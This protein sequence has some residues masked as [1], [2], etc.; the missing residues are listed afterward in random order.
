MSYLLDKKIKRKNSSRIFLYVLIFLFLF[1]LR[2]SIFSGLAYISLSVFRPILITGDNIGERFKNFGSYFAFKNS[3]SMQNQNLQMQLSNLEAR[4]ANYSSMVAENDNLKE[5]LGR[6]K[7][8][9]P[10]ILAA[11]LSKPNQSPYDTILIDGGTEAGIKEGSLVFAVG[12]VPIGRVAF[13][14]INMAKVV[15]FSSPSEK[16]EGVVGGK[17]IF[18]E[19]VGRG[20]GNFEMILPRDFVLQKGDQVVL[21]GTNNY[22]LAITETVVSDPR[23]PYIKALLKSPVNIQE[24]KFVQVEQ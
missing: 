9:T 8:K 19:L 21:P 23:D 7:E 6:K 3:L 20:G 18:M 22:I 5:I 17:N 4:L 2:S 10:M 1:Y 11:I 13:V 15:L 16:T 12:D 14:S 24:L